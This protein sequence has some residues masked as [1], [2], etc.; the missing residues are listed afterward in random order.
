MI[1][2]SRLSETQN[3]LVL[4]YIQLIAESLLSDARMSDRSLGFFVYTG[5]KRKEANGHHT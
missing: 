1:A 5:Q 3:P 4:R 2:M